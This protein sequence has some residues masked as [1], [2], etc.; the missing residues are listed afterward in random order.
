[1]ITEP[2]GIPP[3]GFLTGTRTP[4]KSAMPPTHSNDHRNNRRGVEIPHGPRV[5]RHRSTG[6]YPIEQRFPMRQGSIRRTVAK[7]SVRREN[8]CFLR[9]PLLV[10]PSKAGGIAQKPSRDAPIS[11]SERRELFPLLTLPA[12]LMA[13]PGFLLN[14]PYTATSTRSLAKPVS[15]S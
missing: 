14:A 11:P 1:M 12:A 4:K 10:P 9:F 8:A 15:S 13:V 5:A 7:K 2:A 6:G 3:P